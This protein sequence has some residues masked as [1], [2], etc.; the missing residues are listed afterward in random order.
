[1]FKKCSRGCAGRAYFPEG[2]LESEVILELLERAEGP[3]GR[4][5]ELLRGEALVEEA[6][7]RLGEVHDAVVAG[8][9]LRR[10]P[11]VLD[12]LRTLLRTSAGNVVGTTRN[13]CSDNAS[14]LYEILTCIYRCDQYS[15]YNNDLGTNRKP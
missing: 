8:P 6:Q 3:L 1:M 7:H 10:E 14:N 11:P 5:P 9:P 12:L 2:V 4:R 15:S 13:K